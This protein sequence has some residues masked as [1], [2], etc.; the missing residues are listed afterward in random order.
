MSLNKVV[1]TYF[2]WEITVNLVV[3]LLLRRATVRSSLSSSSPVSAPIK[4]VSCWAKG[5]LGSK[6]S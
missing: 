2:P 6:G 3:F 1:D 5:V 4:L